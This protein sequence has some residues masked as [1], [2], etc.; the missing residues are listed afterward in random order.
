[1]PKLLLMPGLDG[2][3]QLLTDF[4]AAL[5][6][7]FHTVT[8]QYPNLQFASYSELEDFVREQCTVTEPFIIVAESFSTPLAIQYA[9]SH[10]ANLQG[11]VLCAG[12][13]TSPVQGWRRLLG[14]W[15]SPLLFRVPFPNFAAELWLIGPDA[16]ARLLS[17]LRLAIRSVRPKALSAR[18]RAVLSCDMRAELS[19]IAVPILYLRPNQDRLVNSASLSEIRQIKPK[20]S[21]EELEG[22]HLLLQRQPHKAAEVIAEFV[23]LCNRF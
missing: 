15:L 12:F 9:S 22:P 19:Q 11:L 3:G 1:M 20:M 2:T 4:I 14:W 18:V 6:T 23:R 5:P 10:P 16:P 21:V 7:S 13:V 8:L 17:A